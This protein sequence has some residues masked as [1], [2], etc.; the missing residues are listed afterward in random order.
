[1]KFIIFVLM[2]II[3]IL[4]IIGYSLLAMVDEAE[5]E[6]EQMYQRWKESEHERIHT[7]R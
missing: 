4:L 2:T 5:D 3:L 6:V 7:E 1:M